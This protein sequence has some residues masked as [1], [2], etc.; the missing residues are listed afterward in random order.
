[1]LVILVAAGAGVLFVLRRRFALGGGFGKHVSV[2]GDWGGGAPGDDSDSDE[3]SVHM[4]GSVQRGMNE[5][6]NKFMSS[7]ADEEEVFKAGCSDDD[8]DDLI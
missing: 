1:M 4:P 8:E 7:A 3:G 5:A 6:V 2:L